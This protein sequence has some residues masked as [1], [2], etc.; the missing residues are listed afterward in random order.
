LVS[1]LVPLT[2]AEGVPPIAGVKELMD[3]DEV[4]V[5]VQVDEG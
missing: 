1:K 2:Q 3:I 4:A 5:L